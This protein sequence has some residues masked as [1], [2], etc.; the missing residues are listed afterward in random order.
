M[1]GIVSVVQRDPERGAPALTDVVAALEAAQSFVPFTPTA[2]D[3]V[4]VIR[5]CAEHVERADAMLRGIGGVL[6]LC[7]DP[8]SIPLVGNQA[9]EMWRQTE[10]LETALDADP[11]GQPIE[12]VNAALLRL[13]D[14]LWAVGRDRMRTASGAIDLAGRDATRSALTAFAQIEI[15]FDAIDRLEV[16]GRDSAGVAVF[17][18]GHALDL[19]SP[20]VTELWSQRSLDPFF[21]SMSVREADGNLCFTYKAAAEIGEL[22]DNTRRLREAVRT[23][24]LLHLAVSGEAARALVLGH[25]RWASVGMISEPNAHPLS[26]E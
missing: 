11:S 17:V 5:R 15:A 22:G 3:L 14:A 16:R 6:C 19:D 20:S 25:T 10:R 24:P 9:G 26:S 18:R 1:C 21:G 12:D 8:S 4:E 2:P 23:D 7:G 13:K